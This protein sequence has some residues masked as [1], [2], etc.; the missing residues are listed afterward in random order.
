MH[1]ICGYAEQWS[2]EQGGRIGFM[3]SSAGGKDFALRFVRHLC[4]DPNPKGP[5]YQEV[6]MPT[7]LDGVRA[8]R[9]PGRWWGGWG[10]SHAAHDPAGGPEP[11]V[12]T[13]AGAAQ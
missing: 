6:A 9:G 13:S 4:A 1:P 7:A 10:P 11:E 5:G 8:G 12:K 3:V 2:V